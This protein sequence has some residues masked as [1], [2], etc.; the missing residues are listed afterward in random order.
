MSKKSITF[1]RTSGTHVTVSL[2]SVKA[3]LDFLGTTKGTAPHLISINTNVNRQHVNAI[4]ECEANAQA[5]VKTGIVSPMNQ[6][7]HGAYPAWFL[8][9]SQ[10]EQDTAL[11]L[12]VQEQ[13]S[14]T[15]GTLTDP[16]Y[17]AAHYDIV[18]PVLEFLARTNASPKKVNELLDGLSEA[19]EVLAIDGQ[20]KAE[21]LEKARELLALNTS[22]IASLTN[23]K[24]S[25]Q[26][27]TS[28]ITASTK[29]NAAQ[30]KAPE[31]H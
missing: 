1:I 10:K 11:A 5:I 21:E 15:P 4:L 26:R 29:P 7:G 3:V 16:L 12:K 17:S 30:P 2:K 24:G 28:S 9:L 8:N 27:L 18:N 31:A 13:E 19:A 14:V 22:M 23:H 6:N 25:I 20:T